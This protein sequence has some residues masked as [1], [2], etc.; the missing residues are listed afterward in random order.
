MPPQ[1]RSQ[2]RPQKRSRSRTRSRTRTPR[3]PTPT[4]PRSPITTIDF[5]TPAMIAE[6]SSRPVMRDYLKS[7]HLKLQYLENEVTSDGVHMVLAIDRPTTRSGVTYDQ[8][9]DNN[10]LLFKTCENN[11]NGDYVRK[12]IADATEKIFREQSTNF[13]IVFLMT[14]KTMMHGKKTIPAN[15]KVGLII[16]EKGECS[17]HPE[18]PVLKIICALQ[19]FSL[20]L[21][22]SY[23]YIIKKQRYDLGLLELAGCY[24][25][26]RAL[27]AYDRFGFEENYDLKNTRCFSEEPITTKEAS[28]L[29]MS[30]DMRN[31]SYND[32]DDVLLK[33][34]RLGDE[35]LCDE[36]YMDKANKK[37]QSEEMERR[38]LYLD[39]ILQKLMNPRNYTRRVNAKNISK[40][41]KE[42]TK[43][44]LVILKKKPKTMMQYINKTLSAFGGK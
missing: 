17:Q 5:F 1:T 8:I 26:I 10:S 18:I 40:K 33:K 9:L 32:L 7:N 21:M 31:V 22:Y 4:L 19:G 11:V 42:E 37:E 2:T 25:N 36:T 13:D 41:N 43:K 28:T 39:S 16:V 15:T 27:C 38:E 24:F 23:L 14:T 35:P 30:V 6:I 29:P 3:T 44:R 34:K 12:G 20:A